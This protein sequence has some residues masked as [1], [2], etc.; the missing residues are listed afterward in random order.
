ML[1]QQQRLQGLGPA[2]AQRV[3][4]IV[5]ALEQGRLDQAERDLIGVMA[6]AP[7]H[8]EILR[9]FGTIQLMR[10]RPR[11]AVAALESAAAQ[12]A[13][14]PQI[15]NA[16]GGAYEAL[17]DYDRAVAALRRACETGPDLAPCWFNY[18]RV[19][20]VTG[21]AEAA[22]EALR[23]T[24][25]LAPQHAHAR[26]M[27][28]ELL[29]GEGRHA[30]AEAQF[31]KTLQQRPG[32]G[33]AWWGLSTLRPMP[34]G[35]ADIAK[36]RELVKRGAGDAGD[37]VALGF[38][39]AAALDHAGDYAETLKIL[40]ATHAL[41]AQFE[42]WDSAAA[43]A[44]VDAALAAFAHDAQDAGDAG[45]QGGE[46]I[47]IT[48]LP[49]S[50]STLVEQIL[51]SH[52]AVEG[53]AEL[54]DLATVLA[55]ESE[56]QRAPFPLWAGKLSRAQWLALGQRYLERTA[57]WRRHKPCF[58]DKLPDNWLYVGAIRRMLPQARIVLVRRDPLETCFACYRHFFTQHGYT[59]AF[60]TLAAQQRDFDRAAAHWLRIYPTAARAL[61][62]EALI[63]APEAEIR[64]LLDFCGLP[65]ESACL[66][67]HA[68]AR[69]V[70]TP[71]AAQV[72]Q[73]LRRDTARGPR[74]GA[75]L[76]P[77]RAALGLAPF[78][79]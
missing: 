52:S 77:L 3:A 61:Q 60:E 31:R 74:Y 67:F 18:G 23:K 21:A 71:S 1:T 30:E 69:R 37:R 24:L 44:R 59:H 28:A 56:R 13:D 25:K 15:H 27:L 12:R 32:A 19:L 55:E 17:A 35:P 73:P 16:L 36:M 76:D 5:Q 26:A 9:L 11:D 38:A 47:F 40:S 33:Y 7:T 48:S 64:A 49:R 78:G 14:D 57:R 22:I 68:T 53:T 8:A 45:E 63:D 41:A 6:L 51:A 54:T 2:A 50:G 39:L 46:A 62:Y 34:L 43:A 65:F 29:A 70:T 10:G 58:T 72:R 75:L 79:A 42:R 20:F 66:E 4:L